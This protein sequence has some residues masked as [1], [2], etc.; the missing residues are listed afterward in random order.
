[1]VK[2]TFRVK[3]SENSGHTF[4]LSKLRIIDKKSNV[5]F[6][7]QLRDIYFFPKNRH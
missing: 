2:V 7:T 1:M 6:L 4:G 3:L 5:F